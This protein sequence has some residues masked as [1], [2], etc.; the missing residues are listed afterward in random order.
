MTPRLRP[1]GNPDC[2]IC[3]WRDEEI[4]DLGYPESGHDE[5]EPLAM[6]AIGV[7]AIVL[8]G[9]FFFLLAPALLS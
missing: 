4:R 7:A 3:Q 8:L 5:D 6:T 2:R 1:C 9:V